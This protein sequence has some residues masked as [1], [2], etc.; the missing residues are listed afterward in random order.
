ML[1]TIAQKNFKK[2]VDKPYSPCAIIRLSKE[3]RI[4]TMPSEAQ[5]RAT[6]KYVKEHVYKFQVRINKDT[7]A[8]IYDRLNK[9]PYKMSYV[10]D[11]IRKDI[12]EHPDLYD[13]LTK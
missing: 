7:E 9:V 11:L 12:Q 6:K 5:K 4:H 1:Y 8:D 10:K 3:R 2:V 13:D